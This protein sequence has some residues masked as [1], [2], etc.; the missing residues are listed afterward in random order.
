MKVVGRFLIVLVSQLC[1]CDSSLAY[2]VPGRPSNYVRG[3][4]TH[5]GRTYP[6]NSSYYLDSAK[7]VYNSVAIEELPENRIAIEFDRGRD[8]E[9][10]DATIKE[11]DGCLRNEIACL[12]ALYSI[13]SFGDK[14]TPLHVEVYIS[15]HCPLLKQDSSI[16]AFNL[17]Y[18]ERKNEPIVHL[19]PLSFQHLFKT[20]LRSSTN[21][22][23]L[24]TDAELARTHL[25][26][27]YSAWLPY[28][29]APATTLT[30]ESIVEHARKIKSKFGLREGTVPPTAEF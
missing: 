15:R 10:L 21:L 17:K 23:F 22:A 30:A 8:G 14:N 29:R 26:E 6:G 7:K 13:G 12:E 19:I 4:E 11:S 24:G 28:L 1:A 2:E 16:T 27:I 18:P 25:N 3:M 9:I 20:S 5:C